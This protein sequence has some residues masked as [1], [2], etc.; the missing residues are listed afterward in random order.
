MNRTEAMDNV[1]MKAMRATIR[2]GVTEILLGAML[3]LFGVLFY[4]E[5]PFAAL[6]VLF[7][8]V[9]NP[10]GRLLKRRFVYPRIGYARVA[11][12][13]HA[14]RGVAIAAV[15]FVVVVLGGFGVF[16]LIMGSDRGS[17]LGLSHFVPALVGAVMAIG[18]WT[19]AQTYRLI[20]WYIFA[21]LFVLGGICLPLFHVATGYEAVSLESAI[22]G[23][24][25]LIYGI[26]LFLTFLRK[27]PRELP[28]AAE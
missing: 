22:V 21:A 10:L 11:R 12:Q 1:E 8:L 19:V 13:P 9:L 28:H 16:V 24:L 15:A 7:P 5:T 25:A 26:G 23:G 14:L 2:D 18:P 6:S 3:L 20:R 4:L 27:Y 17:S